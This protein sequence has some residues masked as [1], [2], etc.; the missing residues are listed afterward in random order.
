ML[1]NENELHL[2]NENELEIPKEWYISRE[3]IQ[4]IIDE[5][6]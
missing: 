4:H 3:K 6:G 1:Q 5:L 2:Q